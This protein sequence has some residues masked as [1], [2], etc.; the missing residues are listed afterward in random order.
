M[1]IK[2]KAVPGLWTWGAGEG[3]GQWYLHSDRDKGEMSEGKM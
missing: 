2:L 1:E 3:A